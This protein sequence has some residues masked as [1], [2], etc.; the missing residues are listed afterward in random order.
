MQ[1]LTA[2]HNASSCLDTNLQ[3]THF[4]AW[5]IE[6]TLS[7]SS[8]VTSGHHCS[9]FWLQLFSGSQ[10]W[11]MWLDTGATSP[12]V[13]SHLFTRLKHST[14]SLSSFFPARVRSS[15]WKALL[16]SWMCSEKAPSGCFLYT[17]VFCTEPYACCGV[18]AKSYRW[19]VYLT[20]SLTPSQHDALPALV[21]ADI[22]EVFR[23]NMKLFE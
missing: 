6:Q 21:P 11:Q 7:A 22:L 23:G 19:T 17:M 10:R 5:N 4:V 13:H 9:M 15:G 2:T 12:N 1:I 16:F 3:K 20:V 8:C 18:F 14:V